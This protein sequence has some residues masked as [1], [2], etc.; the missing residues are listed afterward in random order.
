MS[1][2]LHPRSMA[3]AELDALPAVGSLTHHASMAYA[4]AAG[5]LWAIG[6][7]DGQWVKA[8]LGTVAR[9]LSRLS[10]SR[11]AAA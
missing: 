8:D 1:L 11:Q 10:D 6:L 3:F 2:G 5:N 4:D 7:R 9:Y